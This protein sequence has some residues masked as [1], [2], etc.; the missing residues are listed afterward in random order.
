MPGSDRRPKPTGGARVSP[1]DRFITIYG[2]MPVL[3]ALGDRSLPID[4]VIIAYNASGRSVDDIVHAARRRNI[5]VEE[6]SPAR[7]KLLAGNGRHDQGVV[8]DVVARRMMP[9]EDFLDK[10]ADRPTTVFLLDGITNPSNVGMILRTASGAGVDGVV[11][12]RQGSPHVGPLVIKASAGVAFRAPILTVGSAAEAAARL[13]SAGYTLY[14]LSARAG[15]SLFEARFA[16]RSALV[17]GGETSGLSVS[18]D[19]DLAIPLHGDV[20]SLNVS[21]AAAVVAFEVTRRRAP[22][23]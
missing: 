4:K 21:A 8:A 15:R 23:R 14:G 5:P 17:L 7:V 3:E 2:R 16:A 6:A 11:L 12:P 10:R 20:E 18:T 13:R 22:R 19:S 1:R 9:L